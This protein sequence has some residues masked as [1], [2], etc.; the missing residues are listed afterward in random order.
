MRLLI[1]E[2]NVANIENIEIMLFRNVTCYERG[3]NN[4]T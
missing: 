2:I 1:H 4:G 3:N